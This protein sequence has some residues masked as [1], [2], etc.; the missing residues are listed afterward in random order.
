M[1][2]DKV[3]EKAHNFRLCLS[4]QKIFQNT[5]LEEGLMQL[6]R[7]ALLW[8][9]EATQL[10][11]VINH[12]SPGGVLKTRL[13]IHIDQKLEEK[14]RRKKARGNCTSIVS[15]GKELRKKTHHSGK[16]EDAKPSKLKWKNLKILRK[17][18]S[19]QMTPMD[20]IRWDP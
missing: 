17:L 13:G 3:W 10:S 14:K 18:R 20:P 9:K 15:Y 8:H 19:Q 2:T 12:H 7:S 16:G 11:E 6:K 4:F 1:L 5:R